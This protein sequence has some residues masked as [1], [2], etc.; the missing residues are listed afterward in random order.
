MTRSINS[1]IGWTTVCLDV[2]ST[3]CASDFMIAAMEYSSS[4]ENDGILGFANI[5][6][7]HYHD[8]QPLT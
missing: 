1:D 4:I 2:N 8:S 6:G 5:Y 3:F 7:Y